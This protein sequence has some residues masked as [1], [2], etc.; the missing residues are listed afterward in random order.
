MRATL[1]T[2]SGGPWAT[3]LTSFLHLLLLNKTWKPEQFAS[4]LHYL[5]ASSKRTWLCM[6]TYSKAYMLSL[7]LKNILYKILSNR[8]KKKVSMSRWIN[9][10]TER[11]IRKF[12]YKSNSSVEI[13][14]RRWWWLIGC[15]RGT[16]V[17]IIINDFASR[18]SE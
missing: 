17:S 9:T 13:Q 5:L 6:H 16:R 12:F 7:F 10:I 1:R 15:C 3:M 18:T 4:F 8:E 2:Q 11:S 14:T